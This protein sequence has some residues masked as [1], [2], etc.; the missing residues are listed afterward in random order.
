MRIG[1]QT[2]VLSGRADGLMINE[3]EWLL[4]GEAD[5]TLYS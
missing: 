1:W 2:A 4:A 3:Q 5:F